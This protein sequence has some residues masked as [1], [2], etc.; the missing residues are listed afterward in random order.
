MKH[1]QQG[2]W[3][4]SQYQNAVPKIMHGLFSFGVIPPWA[5][6]PMHEGIMFCEVET[7]TTIV[8]GERW[9][10]WRWRRKGYSTKMPRADSVVGVRV[11]QTR[12]EWDGSFEPIIMSPQYLRCPVP[13]ER[14]KSSFE[15]LYQVRVDLLAK[16]YFWHRGAEKLSRV[17]QKKMIRGW[18]RY[19]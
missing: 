18:M 15:A 1:L 2:H 6:A 7:E 12:M 14:V 19:I 5:T 16:R 11:P 9:A 8:R 13:H 3:L 4:M 17:E 10:T